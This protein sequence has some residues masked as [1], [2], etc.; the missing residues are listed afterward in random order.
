MKN[1]ICILILICGNIAFSQLVKT[2][3]KQKVIHK[4]SYRCSTEFRDSEEEQK[5][6]FSENQCKGGIWIKG[7]KAFKVRKKFN[8]SCDDGDFL[9]VVATANRCL[10][11]KEW[12]KVATTN[13]IRKF[14]F[15]K[16]MRAH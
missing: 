1:K 15:R 10:P 7:M 8:L 14:L 13:N 11:E 12:K 5:R 9:E 4:V 2:N 16:R 3:K 6:V